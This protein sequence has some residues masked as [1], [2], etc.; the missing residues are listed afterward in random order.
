[1]KDLQK[2]MRKRKLL[3]GDN[4]EEKRRT[5]AR[6]VS[7]SSKTARQARIRDRR[8]TQSKKSNGKEKGKGRKSQ[9][10]KHRRTKHK[11]QV[12]K[13]RKTRKK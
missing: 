6:N 2:D 8:I 4:S 10:R 1:M 11:K 3:K 9:V 5:T 7:M 13:H 12:R